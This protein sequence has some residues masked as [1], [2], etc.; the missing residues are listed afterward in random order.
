MKEQRLES[1]LRR[2]FEPKREEVGEYLR[3]MLNID[4]H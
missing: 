3:R 2:I 4:H 1:V